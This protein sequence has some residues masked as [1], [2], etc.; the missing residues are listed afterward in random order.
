MAG[1]IL[2]GPGGMRGGVDPGAAGR[3]DRSR[4]GVAG[5][6][7]GF[8]GWWAKASSIAEAGS[9]LYNS[10]EALD[11]VQMTVVAGTDCHRFGKALLP[12]STCVKRGW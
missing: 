12:G 3:V 5:G 9:I 10:R 6:V 11:L 7:T 8:E 2:A 1:A 4:A